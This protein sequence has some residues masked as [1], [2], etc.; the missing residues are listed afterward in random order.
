MQLLDLLPELLGAS[1]LPIRLKV[2]GLV[3]PVPMNKTCERL[4]A[5]AATTTRELEE[6]AGAWNALHDQAQSA[7]PF[8]QWLWVYEWWRNFGRPRGWVHDRLQIQLYRDSSG[9]VRAIVPLV[10]TSVGVG[11]LAV[12]KLR[13]FGST[14]KTYLT[15]IP[16]PL[17]D[18][19]WEDA[20][21]SALV[22]TLTAARAR[23]HWCDLDGLPLDGPL[24]RW[25]ASRVESTPNWAHR[26]VLPYYTLSLPDSWE[27]LRGRLKPH[28]KKQLR[29]S[30]AALDRDGHEWTF[31]TVTDASRLDQALSDFFRLH[32]ARADAARGPHHPDR[33]S[34]TTSRRFLQSVAHALAPVG[35]FMIC[36]LLIGDR[37]VAIRLVLVS[38]GCYY[39]YHSAFD[40]ALWRYSLGTTLAGECLKL[41]IRN[42]IRT[43]NF[44]TGADS[45]KT[46]WGPDERTIGGVRITSA[47][48]GGPWIVAVKGLMQRFVRRRPVA[49]EN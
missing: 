20:T 25:F 28:I 36:R 12:R 29:N 16:E 30:Y 24:G 4:T 5:H 37:V 11:P 43:V 48:M 40:P 7:N 42:G 10:L 6:L 27:A 47:R 19:G 3:R 21:A 33:F 32:R 45:S 8:N 35:G 46:R 31:D 41:A 38:G 49:L 2:P 26:R 44:S 15:E 39:L 23:Y 17:V 1:L 9:A 22:G 34:T 13:S 18:P 14:P